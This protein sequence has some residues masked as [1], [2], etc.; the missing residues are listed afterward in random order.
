[1]EKQCKGIN[2]FSL[3]SL[4]GE[5]IVLV[6]GKRVGVLYQEKFYVL[7]APTFE[8]PETVLPGF[9]TIN[10]F[11]WGYYQFIEIDNLEDKDK[12]EKIINYIYHELYFL[13]KVVLDI[14]FLFQ[15][16]RGY[17]ET[18]YKLYEEH[19]TFLNF[20]YEKN[21]IKENPFDREGR[22]IRLL[23]KNLDLTEEGHKVLRELYD[24]WLAY[25][26]KND[27]D[28][29]KRARNI[30]QLEKYYQKLMDDFDKRAAEGKS[31]MEEG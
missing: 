15:S 30:K 5:Y 13:K 16:Y 23:Y 26:D 18:I 25:T 3:E 14:A 21:L 22:I 31:R 7:Y 9:K 17:P 11:D 12:L 10:L 8:K 4:F 29:L 27:T 28:S 24:K 6:S 20:A 19:L 2:N 1:M